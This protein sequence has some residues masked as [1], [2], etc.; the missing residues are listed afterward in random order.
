MSSRV[1]VGNLAEEVTDADLRAHFSAVG[2]V[3]EAEVIRDRDRDESRGF[4]FIQFASESDGAAAIAKLHG[5]EFHGRRMRVKNAEPKKPGVPFSGVPPTSPGS[6][7]VPPTGPGVGVPNTSPGHVGDQGHHAVPPTPL[8]VVSGTPAPVPP[9]PLPLQGFT[10]PPTTPGMG[11][12]VAVSVVAPKSTAYKGGLLA[13]VLLLAAAG[14]TTAWWK[15]KRPP[16]DPRT[17]LIVPLDVY[18]VNQGAEYVGY[19]FAQAMAVNLATVPL[20]KVA[21]V[22]RAAEV[23][24]QSSTQRTTAALDAGAGRLVTGSLTRR[25]DALHVSITLVD[26]KEN[27]IVWGVQRETRGGDDAV[28][29]Q[30]LSAEVARQMGAEPPELF[31]HILSLT[32]GP[33]MA[34]SPELAEALGALRRGEVAASLEATDGLLKRFPAEMAA[35]ALRT[36]ALM[37]Q[38]DAARSPSTYETFEKSLKALEGT[39]KGS[40]YTDFYRAYIL[41]ERG[42]NREAVARF[43]Q[44]LDKASLAPTARAWVLRYRAVGYQRMGDLKRAA[45]ELSES[46]RL[47]PTNA[48]TLGILAEVLLQQGDVEGALTRARQGVALNPTWW[49]THHMVGHVLS[50]QGKYSEAAGSFAEACELANTQLAC[51]RW[52]VELYKAGKKEDAANVAKR[53]SGMMDTALGLYNLACYQALGGD[54]EAAVASLKRSVDMGLI[55][56]GM[57]TDGDLAALKG[58]ARFE[59]LVGVMQ[60]RLAPQR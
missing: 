13:L 49:R 27:R 32:G 56:P 21:P 38:W 2:T 57:A 36:H 22:P 34:S 19:A 58:D 54:K 5:T 1:F 51:S 41:Y 40:P 37:L 25:K 9:T 24:G 29:A 43:T 45:L 44:I 60:S 30:Q 10:P 42:D 20:L 7:T 28:L 17:V 59:K 31:E 39:G 14:G 6:F 11:A 12:P 16:L 52:G 35:L 55:E 47:D 3:V 4:G 23:T 48:W 50:M 33:L 26:A 18:G 8:P 53:A 46:Q 15:F